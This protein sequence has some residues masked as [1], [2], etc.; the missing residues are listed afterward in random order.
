MASPMGR[1]GCYD[2]T[3]GTF[4]NLVRWRERHSLGFMH[5][6]LLTQP[7]R[8]SCRRHKSNPMLTMCKWMRVAGS[9]MDKLT[10]LQDQHAVRLRRVSGHCPAAVLTNG[11]MPSVRSSERSLANLMLP[12]SCCRTATSDAFPAEHGSP[13]AQLKLADN[14]RC[15]RVGK[16][17]R[18]ISSE[19]F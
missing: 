10:L 2:D 1:I 14:H 16:Q 4:H 8:H 18:R 15:A 11:E 19:A 12:A 3:V 9:T 7:P 13:S 6:H 17:S 5:R